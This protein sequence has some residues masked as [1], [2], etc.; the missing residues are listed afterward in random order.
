MTIIYLIRHSQASKN[1]VYNDV[2]SLQTQN[3]SW[4]LSSDGERVASLFAEKEF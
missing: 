4:V 2:C 1:I 3:E